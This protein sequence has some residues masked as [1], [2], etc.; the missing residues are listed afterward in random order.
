MIARIGGTMMREGRV[1]T[2]NTGERSFPYWDPACYGIQLGGF[3][4]DVA[5]GAFDRC[6]ELGPCSFTSRGSWAGFQI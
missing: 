6:H 4:V 3:T 1:R 2:E 5:V